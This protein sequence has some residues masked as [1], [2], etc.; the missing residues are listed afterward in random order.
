MTIETRKMPSLP[1]QAERFLADLD[2][3]LHEPGTL[4]NGLGKIEQKTGLKRLHVF[5]GLLSIRNCEIII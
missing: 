2:K 4:T 5:G 1:P 3:K